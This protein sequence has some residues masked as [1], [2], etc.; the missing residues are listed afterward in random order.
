MTTRQL[1]SLAH[2][3]VARAE[4]DADGQ[5]CV[6]LVLRGQ[7]VRCLE[8]DPLNPAVVYA[9][10]QGQGVFRSADGGRSWRPA[11]LQTEADMKGTLI[12]EP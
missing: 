2:N 8:V 3:G 9:G 11:G 6:E 10:T 1:L 4:S 5:W 7:D 12:V